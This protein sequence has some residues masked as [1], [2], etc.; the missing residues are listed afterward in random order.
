[1]DASSREERLPDDVFP[2]T[3]EAVDSLQR[4]PSQSAFGAGFRNAGASSKERRQICIDERR[5]VDSREIGGRSEDAKK[6]HRQSCFAERFSHRS[7][8]EYCSTS[9]GHIGR[10]AILRAEKNRGMSVLVSSHLPRPENL[11]EIARLRLIEIIE[12]LSKPEL[13]KKAGRAGSVCVPSAPDP[14]P[15]C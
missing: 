5:V 6:S 2:S 3:K 15:S 13:V 7:Q 11:H 9:N 14:S 12:V 8:T 10:P 4:N 1:M